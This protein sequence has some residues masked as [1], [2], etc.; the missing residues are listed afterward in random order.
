MLGFIKNKFSKNRNIGHHNSKH[1]PNPTTIYAL[2]RAQEKYVNS[3][4]NQAEEQ[5]A[6]KITS[7]EME[8]SLLDAD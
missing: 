2:N 6:N 3:E 5:Q 7:L 1:V 8:Q 4:M